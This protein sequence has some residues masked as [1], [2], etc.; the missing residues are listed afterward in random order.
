MCGHVC[1][2]VVCMCVNQVGMF[3]CFCLIAKIVTFLCV[4][5]CL[6]WTVSSEIIIIW[7]TSFY[8]TGEIAVGML[9]M[10]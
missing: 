1:E 10:T 2:C 4:C 6:I 8:A 9:G 7:E 5:V 3:V